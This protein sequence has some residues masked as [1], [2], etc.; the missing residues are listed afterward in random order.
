MTEFKKKN[1]DVAL[2]IIL[3]LIL[4]AV[5]S[6]LA[7]SIFLQFGN[8]SNALDVAIGQQV[9]HT[10]LLSYLRAMDFAFI[11]YT[12]LCLGFLLVFVGA[13]YLLRVNQVAYEISMRGGDSSV[14]FQ[15]ASPGLVLATL[16]VTIVVLTLYNKSL[17]SLDEQVNH[18]AP[19]EATSIDIDAAME[20]IQF[21]YDSIQLTPE[22][23]ASIPNICQYLRENN[24]SEISIEGKGDGD[25]LREY[26]LALG[27]RRAN[28]F[29]AIINNSCSYNVVSR[30]VSYGEERPS[31]R[32]DNASHL[33]ISID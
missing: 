16:G 1:L 3:A 17:V 8:Y 5:F 31:E 27:E 15:T 25:Q 20:S 18:D 6:L 11:K 2:F 22:S 26:E 19:I 12:A 32:D 14:S 28:A 23:L 29:R 7:T 24:V 9:S 10:V 21:E 13:L 4:V 30:S 33:R